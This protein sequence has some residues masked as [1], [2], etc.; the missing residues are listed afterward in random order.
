[1]AT[2]VLLIM[3]KPVNKPNLVDQRG[4]EDM[5]VVT[6][7]GTCQTRICVP[8]LTDIMVLLITKLSMDLMLGG[9]NIRL[10]VMNY[11]YL[12]LL[13]FYFSSKSLMSKFNF[14]Y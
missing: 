3:Y 7:F 6:K 9:I 11:M 13:L 2:V 10:K 1:M 4:K 12:V 5:I 8:I 14:F